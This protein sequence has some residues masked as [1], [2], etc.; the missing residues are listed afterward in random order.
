MSGRTR[1]LVIAGSLAAAIVL[2]AVVV[3]VFLDTSPGTPKESPSP[4]PSPADNRAQVEQS[5][6]DF[7]DTWAEALLQLD[8]SLLDQVAVGDGLQVLRA[9]VEE[10][11]KL[12]QPVRIKVEHSYT[13]LITDADTASVDDRYVNHSVRLN[14]QT[15]EPIEP[16]PN[17]QL[18]KSYT[19]KKVEGRWKIAEIIEYR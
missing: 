18:R 2:V 12:N 5:Y 15:K 16:D 9:Q 1:V 14:P 13:I 17:Q 8:P 4:T 10:Q 7:W 19:L 11:R 6:L 3:F